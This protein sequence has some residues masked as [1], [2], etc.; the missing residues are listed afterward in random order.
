MKT[1]TRTIIFEHLKGMDRDIEVRVDNNKVSEKLP[2]GIDVG[3][4]DEWISDADF[5]ALLAVLNKAK[6]LRVKPIR[7][8]KKTA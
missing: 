8:K 4:V 7:P 5:D 1:S 6:S 2:Y 3:C